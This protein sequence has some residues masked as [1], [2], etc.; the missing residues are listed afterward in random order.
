MTAIHIKP[1]R[2]PTLMAIFA[3]SWRLVIR[4]RRRYKFVIIALAAG[5][6]GLVF[7][8][9]TG[10]SVEKTIASHLVLLGGAT[11]ISVERYD[12]ES[13][14]PGEYHIDDVD[15]LKGIP[16]IVAVAP[17][18]SHEDVKA[19]RNEIKLKV[20]LAGVGGSFWETIMATCREGRFINDVDVEY[21]RHVCVLGEESALGL[22]GDANPIG[23]MV[24]V[25]GLALLV[26]GV[27]G[28]IQGPDTRRSIFMPLTL[29][30]SRFSNM[31]AIKELRIRI[32]HWDVV[33]RSAREIA[34]ALGSA[35]P[36]YQSGIRVQFYPE[37]IKRVSHSVDM[38]K[39]LSVLIF[40]VLIA[41]GCIGAAYSMRSA[42]KERTKEIGLKKAVG[43]TEQMVLFQFLFES[44]I[45][46]FLGGVVGVGGAVISCLILNLAL[47]FTIQPLLLLTSSVTGLL[48]LGLCG[49]LSGFYPA[50]RAANMNPIEAMRFE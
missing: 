29:A 43:W 41:L 19:Y 47:G 17:L 7:V 31:S 6:A 13:P 35:H 5:V 20:R 45:V 4:N 37:R 12:F 50:V 8:V 1:M 38:V 48:A 27:L 3:L 39:W 10:A 34:E 25:D 15:R 46:F 44:L 40:L 24:S 21:R 26:V 18:V 16:N 11:I 23:E 36:G 9:N 49:L 2:R 22:F 30:R 33:E 42:V 28:G 32:D 14:H